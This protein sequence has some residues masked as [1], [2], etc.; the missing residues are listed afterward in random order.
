VDPR[1]AAL[2]PTLAGMPSRPLRARPR[3]VAARAG[4]RR[5][6]RAWVRASDDRRLERTVGTGPGLR[7]VF[8]ALARAYVPARA[9]GFAG[10]IAYELTGADGR[11]RHW[12]I[13]VDGDRARA[14]PGRAEAPALTVK[15]AL[16][17]V[18]RFAAGELDPGGALLSGRVDLAGDFGLASRLGEMFTTGA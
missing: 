3:V 2:P 12:T 6:A 13:R 5:A 18:A 17:D 14:R 1:R 10:E 11:V 16:A 8:T 4:A 7:L 15:L 9:A